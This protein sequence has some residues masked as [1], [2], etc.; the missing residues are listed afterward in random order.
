MAGH[1]ERATLASSSESRVKVLQR[2]GL[3]TPPGK[4]FTCQWTSNGKVVGQH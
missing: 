3:L 1:H 4:I 2:E